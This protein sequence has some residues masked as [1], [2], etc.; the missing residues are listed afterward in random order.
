MRLA[1]GAD[2]PQQACPLGVCDGSGWIL[3]PEDV[4]RPCECRERRMARRRARGV[5]S[6]I[7]RKYRGV[8]FDAPP[9]SDM[10]RDPKS[11]AV[12]RAVKQYVE[13]IDERLDQ[14]EGMCLMG[15]VGT[16]KTSLAM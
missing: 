5:A 7:P 10:A 15:N 8:S 11:A 1:R 2:E 12:C 16:G 14:G 6:A 3:G 4:A 9:L 13:S